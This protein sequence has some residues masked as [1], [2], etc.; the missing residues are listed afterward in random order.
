MTLI[1]TQNTVLVFKTYFK[2]YAIKMFKKKC[3]VI[4]RSINKSGLMKNILLTI[5]ILKLIVTY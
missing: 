1:V 3:A 2:M 4:L 5:L